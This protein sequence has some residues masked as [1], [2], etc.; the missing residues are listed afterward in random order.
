METGIKRHVIDPNGDLLLVLKG[1]GRDCAVW[2][3]PEYD[4]YSLK[5]FYRMRICT[6][7]QESYSVCLR[8]DCAHN[9]HEDRGDNR[10]NLSKVSSSP[11]SSIQA[12]DRV[13]E[14]G[15]D[16]VENELE[17]L[18]NEHEILTHVEDVTEEERIEI[19]VSSK[20]LSLAS[21]FFKRR[22]RPAWASSIKNHSIGPQGNQIPE[23]DLGHL[24]ADAMIIVMNILHGR[25]KNVPRTIDLD[26]IAKVAIIVDYLDCAEPM[27]IYT[28][29][30]FVDLAPLKIA[31]NIYDRSLV[32][33]I[34][35]SSVFQLPE[36]F[37]LVTRIAIRYTKEPISSLELPISNCIIGKSKVWNTLNL[38]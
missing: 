31:Q 20:H 18:E 14:S 2:K 28:E 3:E 21:S 25:A 24:D 38:H 16:T 4:K 34:L 13:N 17:N 9:E 35:V 26:M 5:M 29:R 11:S 8:C 36:M 23:S 7:F 22:T 33:W 19:L 6:H 30:W 27:E 37:T 32:L 10:S 15:I 12:E 1:P